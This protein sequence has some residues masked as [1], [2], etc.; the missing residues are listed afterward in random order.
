MY[1][2]EE[3][4]DNCQSRVVDSIDSE[5]FSESDLRFFSQV[6]ESHVAENFIE[7]LKN[8]YGALSKRYVD[9][10][11]LWLNVYARPIVPFSNQTG[12]E[13]IFALEAELALTLT[14]R[15]RTDL[16]NP[17]MTHIENLV[18]GH[19]N[20]QSSNAT[21]PNRLGIRIFEKTTR[22]GLAQDMEQPK[23]R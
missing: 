12:K 17:Q 14:P 22:V 18:L 11:T 6:Y 10:I 9:G 3:L 1:D 16:K 2:R 13:E 19:Y 21:G 20:L 23:K 8:K 4:I 5:S 15:R 7:N